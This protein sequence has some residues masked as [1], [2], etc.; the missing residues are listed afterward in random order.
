MHF[1][2]S[3]LER[4]EIAAHG[5]VEGRHAVCVN[6]RTVPR[7]R[8]V[9][10]DGARRRRALPRVAAARVPASTIGVHAPLTVD[11]VDLWNRR[12]VGG[13]QYHVAHPGGRNHQTFPVNAYEAEARQLARFFPDG[14][15][16]R[17]DDPDPRTVRPGIALHT[18]WT[19]GVRELLAAYPRAEPRFDE[20]LGEAGRPRPHWA[21]LVDM[22]A[23]AEPARM[24]DRIA[25]IERE[26]R[27]SGLTYNMY[28]DPKGAERPWALDALPVIIGADEVAVDRGGGRAARAAARR[29]ARRP[30]RP[31]VAFEERRPAA[32]GWSSATARSSS[33]A[34]GAAPA[35]SALAVRLRGRPRALAGR[36]L[37]VVADRTERPRARATR[38]RTG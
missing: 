19:C 13:C 20:M 32:T 1:V 6:G 7:P 35:G 36:P 11:V 2:D 29:G 17:R 18:R 21:G 33:A 9:G 28:A 15:H 22:L 12:S 5:L 16:A 24:R 37:V 26:I 14:P 30:L 34:C 38:S 27:D 4:I 3:S 10:G 23:R 8:A 25:T 31:A